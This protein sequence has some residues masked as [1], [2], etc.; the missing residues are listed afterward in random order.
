[1]MKHEAAL[2]KER[3][4]DEGDDDDAGVAGPGEAVLLYGA[5]AGAGGPAKTSPA[6]SP[7]EALRRAGGRQRRGSVMGWTG[8]GGAARR[9]AS[10]RLD[11][12]VSAPRSPPVRASEAEDAASAGDSAAYEAFLAVLDSRRQ[13]QVAAEAELAAAEARRADAVA[14]GCPDVDYYPAY[15]HMV[16]ECKRT[17][18]ENEKR[19]AENAAL[20]ERIKTLSQ[21]LDGM[22][23]DEAAVVR[24][25]RT[26]RGN[27][28]ALCAEL[29]A[30]R[31][32]NR[33]RER[34]AARQMVELKRTFNRLLTRLTDLEVEQ[35]KSGVGGGRQQVSDRF[36]LKP[37]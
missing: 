4:G 32:S 9:P 2:A 5:T 36:S 28:D 33:E 25:V 27:L 15:V 6:K 12:P 26:A 35:S 14:K 20:K 31:R 37:I 23:Q 13:Q 34:E 22:E 29:Y 10:M 17:F 30:T 1:M 8:D 16:A 11:Q 7:V 21:Q 18:Q 3:A 24:R 19:V